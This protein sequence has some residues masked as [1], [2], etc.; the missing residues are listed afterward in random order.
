WAVW[1]A[2]CFMIAPVVEELAEEYKGKVKFC[3]FNVDENPNTAA[4]YSI[5]GIPTLLFFK[6]GEVINQLVGVQ[7]KASIKKLLD[8]NL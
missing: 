7:P 6:N 4:K 8:E 3:K 2:P 1:C 5:R